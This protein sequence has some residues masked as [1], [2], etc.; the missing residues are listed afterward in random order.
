M[1]EWQRQQP[2]QEWYNLFNLRTLVIIIYRKWIYSTIYHNSREICWPNSDRVPDYWCGYGL[3][4]HHLSQYQ[5]FIIH[6]G[7]SSTQNIPVYILQLG[8]TSN[9]IPLKL[10]S[11]LAHFFFLQMGVPFA[12]QKTPRW[13]SQTQFHSRISLCYLASSSIPSLAQVQHRHLTSKW[14]PLITSR[15]A[16]TRS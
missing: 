16:L 1:A 12:T 6:F 15:S 14:I 2:L 11:N 8:S 4:P 9:T 3:S 7:D 10:P 5:S 13:Q